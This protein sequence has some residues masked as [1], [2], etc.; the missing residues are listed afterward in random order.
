MKTTALT[1]VAT[2][3]ACVAAIGSTVS[4]GGG[5]DKGNDAKQFFVEKVYPQLQP[6]CAG[7]HATG[8]H[9]APVFLADNP[10]GSYNA[11]TQTPGYV[12]PPSLSPIV[13]KGLHTGP[14]LTDTQEKVVSEWLLKEPLG[15]RGNGT[16][17]PAN[18]RV[19]LKS[20]GDCM[21][22][23]EW[24]QLGLDKMGQTVSQAGPCISCHNTGQASVF[25]NDDPGMT[26]KMLSQFPYV[27]RLV[28]GTVD[29]SG[30]FSGLVDAQRLIVKG[31]EVP[32][33]ANHHPTF[34]LGS[35]INGVVPY[36]MQDNLT[37]FVS[38]TI[39]KMNRINGCAG[40]VKP[41]AG[42]DGSP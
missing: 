9:G 25:F 4:C 33:N 34:D 5:D 2:L 22:Y 20:F 32:R 30:H 8:K 3:A 39:N 42:P 14:A 6:T 10:D 13:Q 41:D 40:A 19:A 16:E 28:N 29:E 1:L 36:D 7:C 11:V 12:A 26:F 15:Q 17:K 24:T 21:D 35:G 23:S 37:K 27:Q 18:L 31:K 38:N